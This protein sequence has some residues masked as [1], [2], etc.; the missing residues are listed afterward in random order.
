[1]SERLGS[2]I[3]GADQVTL[4]EVALQALIRQGWSL[5]VLEFGLGGV[6]ISRLSTVAQRLGVEGS[7]AFHSGEVITDL[8]SSGKLPGLTLD[9]RRRRQVDVCLG[10]A[11]LPAG[12]RQEVYLAL[13]TP[14]QQDQF[15]RLYG[16]PPEYAPRWAVHHSLD[17][18]RKIGASQND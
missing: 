5:A 1:V 3:Y 6:L 2:W 18:L 16:G 13:V 12:E 9:C 10:V 8:E 17:I 7:S 11:L 14:R 15:I 4:E